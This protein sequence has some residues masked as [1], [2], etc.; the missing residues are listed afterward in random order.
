MERGDIYWVDLGEPFGSEPGYTRPVVIIQDDMFNASALATVIILS[1]TGNVTLRKMPGCVFLSQYETGLPKDC[2]A[3][4]TQLRTIDR[5]RLKTK[6]G[7]LE[8]DSLRLLDEALRSV[9][10]V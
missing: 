2:V 4:A 8:P 3:N 6:A 9:L 7:A 10:G 1:L 5:A